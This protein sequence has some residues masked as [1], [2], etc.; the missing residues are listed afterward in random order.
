MNQANLIVVIWIVD[1]LCLELSKGLSWSPKPS[2]RDI[3]W[4]STLSPSIISVFRVS[5][6]RASLLVQPGPGTGNSLSGSTVARPLSAYELNIFRSSRLSELPCNT[7]NEMSSS[8]CRANKIRNSLV[9]N[10]SVFWL[11]QLKNPLSTFLHWIK[12]NHIMFR[13]M[14]MMSRSVTE[15]LTTWQTA[16]IARAAIRN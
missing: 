10:R 5:G 3:F 1:Y 9:A 13:T 15:V 8:S 2:A 11:F 6:A 16:V 4:S 12:S 14:K 7:A